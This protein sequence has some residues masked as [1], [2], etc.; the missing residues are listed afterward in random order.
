V[1]GILQISSD[2]GD[3][4]K[5]SAF[6]CPEKGFLITLYFSNSDEGYWI[7]GIW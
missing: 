4:T 1:L 5:I 3:K 6:I 7:I 2:F